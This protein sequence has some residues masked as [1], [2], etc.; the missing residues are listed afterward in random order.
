LKSFLAGTHALL[1][2]F[3]LSWLVFMSLFS[4]LKCLKIVSNAAS[5]FDMTSDTSRDVHCVLDNFSLSADTQDVDVGLS[6]PS[7]ALLYS[8]HVSRHLHYKH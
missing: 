4:Y 5:I 8:L 6:S 3:S 7:L 1:D 2:L